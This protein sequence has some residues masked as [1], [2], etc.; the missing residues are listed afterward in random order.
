MITDTKPL[1]DTVID[2]AE[3][4]RPCAVCTHDLADHDKV[5]LRFCQA[6]QAHA[7]PRNCICR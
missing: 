1:V 3:A 2:I 6:T 7:L 5:G 4:L